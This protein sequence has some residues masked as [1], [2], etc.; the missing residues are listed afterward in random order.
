[1]KKG[2][3][4]ISLILLGIIGVFIYSCIV[5]TPTHYVITSVNCQRI[6]IDDSLFAN[7][8]LYKIEFGLECCSTKKSFLVGGTP[9][10]GGCADPISECIIE[11]KSR[12]QIQDLFV[13]LAPET[14]K[15]WYLENEFEKRCLICDYWHD[16]DS[17]ICDVNVSGFVISRGI[18][19]YGFVFKLNSNF[20]VPNRL[21]L[22]FNDHAIDCNVDNR[23]ICYKLDKKKW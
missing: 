2:C 17:M 8:K 6:V 12:K 11:T 22:R 4:I 7:E 21:I 23:P 18:N 1:M 14:S 9:Y 3:L 15:S 13:P 16:V 10:Y 5:T 19:A 20:D